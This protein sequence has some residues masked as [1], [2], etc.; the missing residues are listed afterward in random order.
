MTGHDQLQAAIGHRFS[1]PSWIE[2]ALT[3]SSYGHEHNCS[4]NERLEFLGDAVLQMCTTLLLMERF[5]AAREGELSRLR[6]RLVNTEALAE[7]GAE[8]ALGDALRL[9]RGEEDTGGR[10][11]TR[12]LANATE[13]VLGAVYQDGG[14]EACRALVEMWM[15]PRVAKLGT[16][17]GGKHKWKDARSRLQER[18][19]QNGGATPVY[20]VTGKTGP[21]HAPTY[22]VEVRVDKTVLGQGTG[23]S[24][25]DAARDAAERALLAFGE[26]E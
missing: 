10:T 1:D 4:D 9:G 15:A 20:H 26:A 21:S 14:F 2:T 12:N 23:R 5:G 25:R 3:H 22:E 6:S 24:K 17:D 13:A 7:I 11:R 19:Q 18:T 8:L 16:A